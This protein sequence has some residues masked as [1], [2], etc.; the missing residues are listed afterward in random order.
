MEKG[1]VEIIVPETLNDITLGQYQE[2]IKIEEPNEVD[3]LRIFYNI[4]PNDL[5]TL[6][7]TDVN[8]LCRI[9]M[10]I[11]Q[12][13]PSHQS[14]FNIGARQFGFIPN[15]EEITYGENKDITR[16]LGNWDRMHNCMAVMY[17]PVTKLHRDKYKI[18]EYRGSNEYAEIMKQAPLG[19]VLGSM[20][21]FWTLTSA[22]LNAIPN[23]LETEMSKTK[24]KG[25]SLT[26]KQYLERN[27]AAI[28]NCMNS[29]KEISEDMMKSL[30]FP[31]NNV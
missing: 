26:Q 11:I 14:I 21:F 8:E 10:D 12:S 24:M 28:Q 4:H 25:S 1:N 22:L 30:N 9:I 19:A 3:I 5:Y 29:L 18:E 2:F 17:R 16:Y 7:S 27:G 20:V 23:Y 13:K 6:K 31:Y 15:L